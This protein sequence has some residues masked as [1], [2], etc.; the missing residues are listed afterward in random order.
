[1]SLW[2][3][4]AEDLK[5]Q[6]SKEAQNFLNDDAVFCRAHI[7]ML[8]ESISF[9]FDWQKRFC[10]VGADKVMPIIEWWQ[11][12][13]ID[14]EKN[15]EFDITAYTVDLF[16]SAPSSE[17]VSSTKIVSLFSNER[18][19]RIPI[20]QRPYSWGEREIGKL[21]DDIAQAMEQSDPLFIG[22]IQ[23]SEPTPLYNGISRYDIIDGQ[24]RLTSLWLLSILFDRKQS[25]HDPLWKG[26]HQNNILQTKVNRGEAN[27]DLT[28]FLE[29][30]SDDL[31]W[32]SDEKDESQNRNPY[33]RNANII[34]NWLSSI[35]GEEL[36]RLRGV[37]SKELR[38]VVIETKA[39]LSKTLQIFDT[40]NTAGMD[41]SVADL[42]KIR[43]YEYLTS[44]KD[45]DTSAFDRISALYQ[46]IELKNKEHSKS[47]LRTVSMQDILAIIQQLIAARYELGNHFHA[48]SS[49]KFFD[50]LFDMLLNIREHSGW[51]KVKITNIRE[52]SDLL[53]PLQ[54]DR[55]TAIINEHFETVRLLSLSKNSTEEDLELGFML[56][57]IESTRYR[58]FTSSFTIFQLCVGDK[59][60]AK[61]FLQRLVKICVCYSLRYK[62]KIYE[63]R[64]YLYSSTQELCT[65]H[66]TELDKVLNFEAPNI[67][68][69][70][71][72]K[73]I[74][75]LN[76]A[77][78]RTWKYLLCYILEYSAIKRAE[79]AFKREENAFNHELIRGIFERHTDIEHIQAYTPNDETRADREMWGDDINYL[80]NL[81]LLESDINRSI[82]NK[83]FS[84]K[85]ES[86]KKS[87]FFS[88]K[89]LVEIPWDKE[90]YKT[91]HREKINE[92]ISYLFESELSQGNQHEES[93]SE[94]NTND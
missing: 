36:E 32:K 58:Q 84:D 15:S 7:E 39:G 62:K 68:A 53:A 66:C 22:S 49:A 91:R 25:Q 44:C 6:I 21:L 18:R 1:M 93:N 87:E 78:N 38:M 90:A 48:M 56:R 59:A 74:E 30:I 81:V 52:D 54:T 16:G 12:N 8:P 46:L 88:V 5:K 26:N 63:A 28:R 86:Y 11:K 20:Y 69:D 85:K 61:V 71:L 24:Q 47:G 92:V 2:S 14:R 64:N 9:S 82:S 27:E 65:G 57:M 19:Y 79:K 42:F 34:E 60:K 89:E 75:D 77:S 45:E 76:V 70:N 13:V 37:L 83:A 73:Y 31:E 33:I 72:K 4:C 41:L 43:Y 94:E 17:I 40:I 23:L 10:A 29:L 51:N 50:H 3:A 35:E 55:I 67:Q 80:G